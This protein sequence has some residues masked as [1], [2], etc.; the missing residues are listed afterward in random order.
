MP[1]LTSIEDCALVAD[2]ALI[3]ADGGLQHPGDL[4]KAIAFGA[5]LCMMGRMFA[6]TNLAPGDCYDSSKEL[7][8]SYDKIGEMDTSRSCMADDGGDKTWEEG[9]S[10]EGRVVYKRYRGMASAEAR[11]GVLKKASVEGVS[12]LIK[13]V[14]TTEDFIDGLQSN[15]QAS[16]SYS[17]SLNWKSFRKNTKKMRISSAAWSESQTHVEI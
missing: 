11:K 12:G 6:G 3:I 4:A 8:C 2:K 1:L 9:P 14:G 17:G 7:V 10:H 13:Y 5:D 15:M 16:L